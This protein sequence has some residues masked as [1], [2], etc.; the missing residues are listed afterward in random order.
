MI[1]QDYLLREIKRIVEFALRAMGLKQ[2]Q[3]PEDFLRFLEE[4]SKQLTG[5]PFE[6]LLATPASKLASLLYDPD[7][8]NIGRLTACG[9]LLA[10]AGDAHRLGGEMERARELFL[11]GIE[12]LAFTTFQF[13]GEASAQISA[14]LARLQ[15]R[16]PSFNYDPNLVLQL[17]A[18]CA[19]RPPDADPTESPIKNDGPPAPSL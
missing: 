6:T 19:S 15:E 18:L 17:E 12:L 14:H 7:G 10:E 3:E 8:R 2:E 11:R 16:I 4:N 1:R 5:L 13:S 9:A